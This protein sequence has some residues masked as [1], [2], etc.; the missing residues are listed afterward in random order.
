MLAVIKEMN[1]ILGSGWLNNTNNI[2]FIT[3]HSYGGAVASLL[4]REITTVRTTPNGK[5]PQSR[6]FTYTFASPEV[7]KVTTTVARA[8]QYNNIFNIINT[9]DPVPAAV[10]A[11]FG[12]GW[13]RYGKEITIHSGHSKADP[14]AH[15]MSFYLDWMWYRSTPNSSNK[16]V[17]TATFY[18]IGAT[19]LYKSPAGSSEV[20]HTLQG[21]RYVNVN[22]HMINSSGDMWYWVQNADGFSGGAFVYSGNVIQ[23]HPETT[24]TATL[25]P[26][27]GTLPSGAS[28]TKTVRYYSAIGTLPTP[29]RS[30]YRFDGWFTGSTT[31]TK[32]TAETIITNNVTYYARWTAVSTTNQTTAKVKYT[33]TLN[34]NGGTVSQSSYTVD[35]GSSL[36]LP[37]PNRTGYTF[38]GWYLNG[39]KLSNTVTVNGSATLTAQWTAISTT[40]TTT[41]SASASTRVVTFNAN[42]GTINTNSGPASTGTRSVN[43]NAAVGTLPTP[44]RSGYAFNGWFTAQTGGTRIDATTKITANVTYWARWTSV[45]TMTAT[46]FYTTKNDVPVRLNP[47]DTDPITRYFAQNTAVTI[48][49]QT[50]NSSGNVWYR[51]SSG[52]WIFSG[53]LAGSRTVTFNANGGSVS[54]GTR[55]VANGAAVGTLPTPTR[56]GN[57]FNGWFT[58]Q[59]GGSRIDAATRISANVTYWARWTT[60]TTM[61]PTT[62]YTAKSNVPIRRNPFDTDPIINYLSTQNISVTVDAR[63]TNSSG[64]VWY[65]LSNGNWI[66]SG[67]LSTKRS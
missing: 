56:S 12:P 14:A 25:N 30:G 10:N 37:S 65:R 8:S 9:P 63:T 64:N 29:T 66:F 32:V 24:R 28:N 59:T 47:F 11:A 4:A 27:N 26:N 39:N 41:T 54:E 48:D 35:A 21:A 20:L 5:V 44:T 23:K 15:G 2:Y 33:V 52:T 38:A 67:N 36:T 31:G 51:T 53:N 57:A 42:N 7:A 16:I 3:G 50:T 6:V 46:T 34:P 45:T 17:S 40:T 55:S 13:N 61:T 1:D 60:I 18:T 49:A 19:R 58:A 43:S 62:L 22:G